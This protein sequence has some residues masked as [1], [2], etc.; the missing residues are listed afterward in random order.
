MDTF[1]VAVIGYGP[2]GQMLC[3]QLG[4]AGHSV[5]VFEKHEQ[6]YGLSRAGHIDDEIMRTLQ[7]IGAGEEFREDAVAWETYDMRNEAFGGDLLLSLDWS[8]V[9]P[10]GWRSHWIFYQNNLELAMHRQVEAAGN[11][12]L[13][14]GTEAV[15][16]DQDGDGVTLTVRD[17]QSGAERTVRVQYLVGTDGANSFVRERLGITTTEG[18]TGPN[19]LVID[20]RQKRPLSFPFDNGQ[21]ADPK[22]PGCLFQLGKSHRRWEFTLRDDENPV[23][24]D[25]DR[26]W[27]LLSP[28]VTPEDVE[29]IRHPIYRFR[30]FIADEWQRGRVFLAG[31]AAHIMWPFAGEGMCNGIRDASALVWRLD[32][33]LR[34]LAPEGLLDSYTDDRKPNVQGWTDLSREI[35]LPCIIMDE[36]IAAQRDAGFKAAAEDPSLMPEMT[37]PPGPTAFSRP[38][39]PIAG[40]PACQFPVLVDGQQGLVDDLIGTGFQLIVA[41]E[42]ALAALSDEQRRF[43]RDIGAHVIHVGPAGSGAPAVDLDGGYADW[44]QELGLSAVLARPDFYLYGGA[45]D[46]DDT[47]ALV[48]ALASSLGTKPRSRIGSV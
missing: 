29:I 6:L 9:G 8:V 5:A 48:A 17:R 46:A 34:D 27:Q 43:L 14:L 7:K 38:D 25:I 32:L 18:M 20:T 47:P 22:R 24:F 30:E 19:Q 45:T 3:A 37:V 13:L 40:M 1:D 39:D 11:V 4:R 42:A 41:D 33:V 28:W 23:D 36:E 35:G 10:H 26:I 12:Q 15:A 21:F 2:V 16:F 31:D 44:F